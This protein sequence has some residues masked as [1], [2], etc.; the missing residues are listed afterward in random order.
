MKN[1]R[2]E[3]AIDGYVLCLNHKCFAPE[4]ARWYARDIFKTL[5]GIKS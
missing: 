5:M 3:V 1:E 4:T 2:V